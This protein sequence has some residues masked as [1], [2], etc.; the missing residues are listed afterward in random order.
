[1]TIKWARDATRQLAAAH[2]YVEADNPS[3]ADRLVLRV[4]ESV[5]RLASYPL[6][7]REGRVKGTRELV[8]VD[9]PYIVAYRIRSKNVIQVLAVL[10]GKRRWPD[11][12]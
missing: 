5:A 8:I 7:G 9:T 1:M 10:H 4:V 11:T 3:A 12:F 6:A 2:A